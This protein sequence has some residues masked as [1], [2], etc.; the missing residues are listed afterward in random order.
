MDDI[1]KAKNESQNIDES[2]TE[3]LLRL[4]VDSLREGQ[5]LQRAMEQV[6]NTLSYRARLSE[7]AIL[8]AAVSAALLALATEAPCASRL[9]YGAGTMLFVVAC[10]MEVWQMKPGYTPISRLDRLARCIFLAGLVSLVIAT[11]VLLL[12]T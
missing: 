12:P 6:Q 4:I 7:L 5:F 8:A 3:Y 10:A 1:G 11:L 2:R 9:M